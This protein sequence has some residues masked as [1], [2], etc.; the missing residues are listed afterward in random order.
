[1]WSVGSSL[2]RKAKQKIVRQS[3]FGHARHLSLKITF[4]KMTRSSSHFGNTLRWLL[5]VQIPYE[6]T[7]TRRQIASLTSVHNI[8]IFIYSSFCG[9]WIGQSRRHSGRVTSLQTTAVIT[10]DTRQQLNVRLDICR[11][12]SD[13]NNAIKIKITVLFVSRNVFC[14]PTPLHSINI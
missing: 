1:V 2:R 14:S 6:R 9:L 7:G 13:R 4:S 8:H 12:I 11:T 3:I 5:H 10:Q